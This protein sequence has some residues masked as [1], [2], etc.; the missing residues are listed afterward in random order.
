ME[1]GA[2]GFSTSPRGGPAIHAGTPSTFATHQE[3]IELANV[4]AE[5]KGCF[6]FN[7]FQMVLQPE[8]GVPEML[9]KIKTMQ[10]GN[11][12]RVRP[13]QKDMG[14]KSI[15]YMEEAQKRGQDIYGVVIPYQHIRRF[16]ATDCFLF[17]GLPSWEAIKNSPDLKKKLAD[18][19]TRRKIEQERIAC[20]GKLEF[21]EWHGWD[22]V[23]FEHIKKPELKKLERKNVAEIARITEKAPVDAFFDTWLED[24]L[25]SQI[26]YYGLANAHPE[27]LAEMIK[28]D[29]SLIGTDVGAHLDRFFWHGAPTKILGYWTREKNLFSLEQAVH[30]ITGFPAKRLRLNRGLLKEGMPA[31]VTVFD[32]DKIDDL[33]SKQLPDVI[34]AQEVRRHPPGMKAVVVNGATVVQD[35]ECKDVFPGK[36]RR[37]QLCIN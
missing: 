13:G 27:L 22:R 6:Q 17:N 28:S 3:I 4:A 11:E 5:Y 16:N 9:T 31:D 15:K 29:T 1:L 23:V 35:G 7:G 10:I 8:S 36:V 30:K 24:D 20:Q 19:E 33:V 26:L 21:P 32:P 18:K 14:M 25:E 37:Q 2:I 12:F 34:D